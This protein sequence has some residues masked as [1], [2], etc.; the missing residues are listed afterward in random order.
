[1]LLAAATLAA[2][3]AAWC[4]GSGTPPSATADPGVPGPA[5]QETA[6]GSW[7]LSDI[8]DYFTAPARWNGS[9][10][11]WFGG[12]LVAIAAT[13]HYDTQVR[14]HFVKTEGPSTSGHDLQDALPTVAVFAATALYA[15]LIGDNSGRREAWAMLESG[16]LSGVTA[17]ALKYSVRRLGPD[18]TSDPNQWF[19]SG[20]ASFPSLHTTAAFAV[21]TVLAESG[22]DD[23]R[24]VRRFLGYGLGAATGYERIKHSAHWL[25]DTVAGAALGCASAHFV[26][27]RAYQSDENTGMS[28]VPV[29]RGA[30]L[31]YR[32]SL[33]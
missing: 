25:S 30:M 14:T 31:A 27:H 5:S 8:K 4:A 9:D 16:A 17:L 11:A 24:W 18:Q 29:T 23:Y 7:P 3:S 2:S 21:G 12:S 19:K 26:M 10:W 13:H 28:V 1:M 33:P 22:G 15:N 20:G 6:S 32:L